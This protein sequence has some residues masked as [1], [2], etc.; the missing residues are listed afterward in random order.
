[1]SAGQWCSRRDSSEKFH[2]R[3]KYL[4][5]RCGLR[6]TGTAVVYPSLP[7]LYPFIWGKEMEVQ[8]AEEKGKDAPSISP[9][10]AHFWE[11]LTSGGVFGRSSITM[12]LLCASKANGI[13]ALLE[14]TPIRT[15]CIAFTFL[16]DSAR[17]T[18]TDDTH[19]NT[20][21][22]Y[23]D[24][25]FLGKI[26]PQPVVNVRYG[27]SFGWFERG[28]SVHIH[29]L[30]W[31]TKPEGGTKRITS[32]LI[33]NPLSKMQH[34]TRQYSLSPPWISLSCLTSGTTA[35]TLWRK[36]ELTIKD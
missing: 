9:I 17:N 24:G 21:N 5:N 28:I 20:L 22:S 13:S 32:I 34:C 26:W 14:V 23:E 8:R 6:A 15:Y 7:A 11:F 25:S 12:R 35:K 29:L 10:K 4:I 1:M 2:L 16:S 36:A 30:P 33:L 19:Q 31:R 27:L 18:C 3:L